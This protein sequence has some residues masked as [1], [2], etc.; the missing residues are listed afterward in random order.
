VG[1]RFEPDGAYFLIQMAA[2]TQWKAS[3]PKMIYPIS[4]SRLNISPLARA[5]AKQFSDYRSDPEI[6][7]YQSWDTPYSE[8]Q[9]LALIESQSGI[10]LPPK[11]EW[12]Q[13]A[14]HLRDSDA[15]IGDLALHTL[16]DDG[17]FELGYTIAKAF[18]GQGYAR[19][20]T[21]ALIDFLIK[22]HGARRFIATPDSRNLPSIKLL[23]S[24]G[25]V[26]KPEKS[27]S[28]F[29]KG[30]DVTVDYFEL[31]HAQ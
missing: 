17:D 3:N 29:F 12:L 31:V 13:L 11:G 14:I 19:E 18:Q 10:E 15:H 4:T 20:A 8:A 24:L 1:R 23:I 21:A 28:E 9:A 6:A 25:F 5:D 16:E 30:E 27:W 26:Q 22:N 7:R 2:C